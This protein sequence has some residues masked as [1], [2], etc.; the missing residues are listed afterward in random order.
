MI[1][2]KS[3]DPQSITTVRPRIVGKTEP[4]PRPDPDAWSLSDFS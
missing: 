2:E 1:M 3:K 4:P